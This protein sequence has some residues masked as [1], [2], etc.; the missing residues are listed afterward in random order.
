[1]VRKQQN[2]EAVELAYLA[3]AMNK[4]RYKKE[5]VPEKKR[6]TIVSVVDQVNRLYDTSLTPKTTRRQL[7]RGLE[8]VLIKL[9]GDGNRHCPFQLK[10]HWQL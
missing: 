4:I 7:K 3:A 9:G 2:K 1:M 10:V 5:H 6:Q 8:A